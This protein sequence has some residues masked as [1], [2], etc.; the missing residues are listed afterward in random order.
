MKYALT[1]IVWGL[2]STS[3]CAVAERNRS[4]GDALFFDEQQR[5]DHIEFDQVDPL[6]PLANDFK[7]EGYSY[8]SSEGG[9][10]WALITL[11]NTSTGQRLLKNENLVVTFADGTQV[12]AKNIEGR[13]DGGER[14]SKSVFF[15]YSR[16]PIVSI[17]LE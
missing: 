3:L 13:F 15:G 12:Y 11:V 16:F 10:R 4:D 6:E 2:L 8:L 1:F 14:V 17:E 7:I 9:E 5:L